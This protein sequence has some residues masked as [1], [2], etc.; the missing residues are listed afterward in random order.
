MRLPVA[1]SEI[2]KI[3]VIGAGSWGTTLANHLAQ[4]GPG[5][6]LWVREEQATA[7]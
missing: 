6:D 5:V 7:A 1:R 3:A 2:T 4:K